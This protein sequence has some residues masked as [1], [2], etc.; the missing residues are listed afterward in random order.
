MARWAARSPRAFTRRWRPRTFGVVEQA[1]AEMRAY[2]HERIAAS[3]TAPGEDLG[4]RLVEAEVEADR[5]S[6]DNIIAMIT[7]FVF[8]GWRP[9]GGS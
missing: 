4:D 2:G 1:A 9:P 8:A 7:G 3:R 6:E 5:L